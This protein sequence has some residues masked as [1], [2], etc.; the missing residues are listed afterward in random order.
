MYYCMKE[1]YLLRGWEKL[2]TGIVKRMSGEVYFIEPNLYAKMRDYSWM[3]FEGSPFLTKD[4]AKFMAELAKKG[5]VDLCEHPRPLTEEQQYRYYPNRFLRAVHW[6]ITGKCNCRCRHCYMSAP[7]GN[8]GDYSH[9]ECMGIVDQMEAAGV[10]LV[11]LTGG[12]ALMRRDFLE[13]VRR[14]T[15]AG[16]RVQTIMSNG[17]LVDENLLAALT[18]LGQKPEFNISFDGIGCHDWL[19]GVE[20]VEQKAIRAFEL[21][22]KHGFPTGA[23]YCLRKGNMDVFRESVKLLGSLGLSS[24][25]VNGLSAEGEALNI[26]DIFLPL[27]EEYQ[28]YLDYLPQYYEDGEPL[29][30]M[31]CGMFRSMGKKKAIIPYIK[32]P[33]DQDCGDYCMCGHA[34]NW[35][36]ISQDGYIVPCIPIGSVENGR[37][38]FPNIR[39]ISLSQAL[40]DSFYMSFID[41][42]LNTYF[43][44]HP[45]CE[46][47]AYRNRCAGGC[48]GNAAGSGDLM[49]RDEK[50]CAFFLDG[51]YEKEKQLL[52]ELGVE[53]TIL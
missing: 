15:D 16:I 30:L 31:L 35:M 8:A 21:C 43:R 9:E 6:A 7:S 42:R 12:E 2:P 1:D 44:E 36:Y 20:G 37:N 22:A 27:K 29:P 50:T 17:V 46:A 51:W 45:E 34:R 39:E 52:S 13:I 26:Q 19:R 32:K 4:Q 41:T 47:C 24:L 48:R 5:L 38:K 23:E 49:A 33:E 25:K 28:F 18:D 11:S 3:I 14:L 53:V 10:Q 40:S